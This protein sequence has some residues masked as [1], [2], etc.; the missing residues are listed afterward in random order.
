MTYRVSFTD[1][2]ETALRALESDERN[3]V[4]TKLGRIATCQYRHPSDWNFS[5]MDG[6]ADGRFEIGDGLRVFADI[7]ERRHLI[8]IH[9]IGRRENLYT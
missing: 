5:R 3:R 1:E 2:G 8:R 6:C 9:W 7:D 4:T